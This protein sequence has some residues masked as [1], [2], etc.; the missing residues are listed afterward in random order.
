MSVGMKI[1]KKKKKVDE[2]DTLVAGTNEM[3]IENG[4]ELAKHEENDKQVNV[5]NKSKR[6]QEEEDSVN[7]LT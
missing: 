3:K 4:S 6:D 7:L 5:I 1:D 2:V